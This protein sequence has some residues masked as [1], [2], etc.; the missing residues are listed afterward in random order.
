VN[1]KTLLAVIKFAHHAQCLKFIQGTVDVRAFRFFRTTCSLA[2]G[3]A[4]LILAR[5]YMSPPAN[6]GGLAFS[7]T[8][9]ESEPA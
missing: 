1:W 2:A 5:F 4:A 3:E 7:E 6:P 9:L 8:A